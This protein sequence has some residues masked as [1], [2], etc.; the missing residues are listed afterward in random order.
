M[1]P[2]L[3]GRLLV[4][5]RSLLRAALVPVGWLAAFCAGWGLLHF[6]GG[7]AAMVRH[8]YQSFAFLAPVPSVLLAAHYARMVV[9]ARTCLG[10][11]PPRRGWRPCGGVFATR[12]PRRC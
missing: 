12:S 3:A 8:F 2:V 4:R 7:P 1:Q 5:E 6:D 10:L 11:P 9:R